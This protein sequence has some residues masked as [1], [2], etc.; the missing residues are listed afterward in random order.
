MVGTRSA[1]GIVLWEWPTWPDSRS[2][3]P[4]MPRMTGGVQVQNAT[5]EVDDS[6]SWEGIEA[7]PHRSY[8]FLRMRHVLPPAVAA[9]FAGREYF[10]LDGPAVVGHLWPESAC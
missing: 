8:V 9:N 7:Y 5:G 10:S 3:L 4:T 6:E 2:W 1:P